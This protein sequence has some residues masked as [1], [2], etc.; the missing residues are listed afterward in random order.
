MKNVFESANQVRNEG[1][2][3][4]KF[5]SK[6]ILSSRDMNCIRGGDA[7]DDGGGSGIGTPPPP[8]P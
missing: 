1:H 5:F 7:G 6:E 3:F 2:S 4:S 8:E